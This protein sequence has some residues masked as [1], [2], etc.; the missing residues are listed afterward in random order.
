[1]VGTHL[2]NNETV[3]VS[4][5]PS[6]S[7]DKKFIDPVYSGGDESSKSTGRDGSTALEIPS[8]VSPITLEM[9]SKARM[10]MVKSTM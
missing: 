10:I 6:Q 2:T 5:R 3:V 9:Q 7:Q 4:A 1:M 8:S